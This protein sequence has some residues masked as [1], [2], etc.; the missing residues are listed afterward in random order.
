[1]RRILG[2]VVRA[3]SRIAHETWYHIFP[4]NDAIKRAEQRPGR[5][6]VETCNICN[7]NCIF[8]AYRYLSRPK[9]I[10]SD[11]VFSKA[12]DDFVACGGGDVLLTGVVG[13]PLLD[14]DIADR[15]RYCRAKKSIGEILL[16]TNCI[17]LHNVG[18]ASLLTSGVSGVG[19]STT[20]FDREMYERIF[21]SPRYEKMKQNVLALLRANHEMGKPIRVS[22]NLRID[23]PVAEVVNLPDFQEVRQ[24]ADSVG[25]TFYF[26]NWAGKIKQEDLTGNM[27]L[28]PRWLHPL[29]RFEPCRFLYS[30]IVVLVDGSIVMCG[31]RDLDGR[32]ELYLG[33]IR[34]MSLAE[35][36]HSPY[37]R[38][39]RHRWLNAGEI[40]DICRDCLLYSPRTCL[41][42]KESKRRLDN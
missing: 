14:P 27:K 2:K 25:A 7:A 39:L 28:R 10:M 37:L 30:G 19:I 23:K 41:M 26:D 13:D 33:N 35:A 18:V 20:G 42:V 29:R 15:I 5:L 17:N 36:Y 1:M 31:C 40:A 21:R 32:S 4:D 6:T 11:A 38:R 34:E 9:Q 12:I 3:A 16:V 22:I 24:L 8:C